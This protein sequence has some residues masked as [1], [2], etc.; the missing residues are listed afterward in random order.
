MVYFFN[1]SFQL[2]EVHVFVNYGGF[3]LKD[4]SY[5]LENLDPT[6]D[7]ILARESYDREVEMQNNFWNQ[8]NLINPESYI[9]DGDN[10]ICVTRNLEAIKYLKG[11]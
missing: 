4:P 2:S 6:W 3:S 9:A 8:L 10:F 5:L 1:A 11:L 7:K